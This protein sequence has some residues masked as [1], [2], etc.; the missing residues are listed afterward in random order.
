M[1]RVV[2]LIVLAVA[3]VAVPASGAKL[4]TALKLRLQT[5]ESRLPEPG[6]IDA[7]AKKVE[8]L[9]Q[10]KGV[11]VQKPSGASA[12]P[13]GNGDVLFNL[14]Q[15]VQQL[16]KDV[17][18]L[19]GEIQ[20]VRH[21]LQQ[22][23]KR[24]RDLYVSLNKRLKALEQKLGM[25]AVSGG[26]S[27]A[28][29]GQSAQSSS[30]Q[31]DKNKQDSR[32]KQNAKK[33]YNKAFATLSAGKFAKAET[34]FEQFV[35]SN[36]HSEYTDNAWYWLGNT[37]YIARDYETAIKALQH[38]SDDFPNSNKMPAAIYKIGVIRNEQGKMERARTKLQ[39]VIQTY[40][41]S[42][43]ADLARKQL[44]AMKSD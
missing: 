14:Y 44:D 1:K 30:K 13:S 42:N 11:N 25:K 18:S 36:P 34:A 28:V 39:E 6:R 24:Q 35:Q 12:G 41:K 32:R 23:K 31:T 10:T 3:F 37:R 22:R 21:K 2:A 27:S 5:I 38:V 33:A 4:S 8:S 15:D 40:P 16:R 26:S 17:R 7:L 19:R 29:G 20:E 43:A 9:T